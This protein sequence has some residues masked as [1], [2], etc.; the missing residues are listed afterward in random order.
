MPVKEGC[1]I[2]LGGIQ[3]N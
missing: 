1:C 3:K 2:C